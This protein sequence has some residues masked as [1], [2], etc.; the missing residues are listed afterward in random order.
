[1]MSTRRDDTQLSVEN[2]V[3]TT[4]QRQSRNIVVLKN[5]KSL[6]LNNEKQV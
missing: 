4:T 5:V 1:M 2:H 3:A 6:Y